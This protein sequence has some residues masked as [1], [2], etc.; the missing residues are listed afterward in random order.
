MGEGPVYPEYAYTI[1]SAVGPIHFY[2]NPGNWPAQPWLDTRA[3]PQ[4]SPASED[5]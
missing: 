1:W 2:Y 3:T 5:K 4:Q